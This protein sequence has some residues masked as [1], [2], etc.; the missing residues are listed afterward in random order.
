MQLLTFNTYSYFKNSSDVVKQYPTKNSYVLSNSLY[1]RFMNTGAWTTEYSWLNQDIANPALT[2][3]DYLGEA[4]FSNFA[5][6]YIQRVPGSPS[7]TDYPYHFDK[8]D[9]MSSMIGGY[10]QE[11]SFTDNT[12]N[13]Y[14][15][16][17]SLIN[18]EDL[19]TEHLVY[20]IGMYHYYQNTH[21]QL[22]ATYY[23]MGQTITSEIIIRREIGYKSYGTRVIEIYPE[24]ILKDGA[25]NPKYTDPETPY[26]TVTLRLLVECPYSLEGLLPADSVRLQANSE[27]SI[28]NSGLVAELK[29]VDTENSF[30][31]V[32]DY[33][34]PYAINGTSI[35]EGGTW[36]PYPG[37]DD[38]DGADIPGLPTADACDLG[39]ITMYNPTAAQ[40]KALSQ[41][42]WSNLFDLDSYKKLFSDP[43]ESIIGL[44][45]V[46]VAPSIGGTKTV[47]FGSIDSGISMD[48]LSSQYVQINCG[49]VYINKWVFSFLDSAPYSKIYI[50]LP[51]IGIQELSAD[52]IMDDSINVVYNID[53][54][55]GACGCFIKSGKK[56]VLY[57]FNG[58]CISNIPLT[59]INFSSA[60]Q[61]AVSAVCSGAAIL[62]GMST[63]AA[64]V[65][66]MG[67]MGLLTS[68]ANTAI[69]SKPSVQRSGSLGG[70]SGILS[71]QKP[72][73]IIERPDVSVPLDIQRY[74]GQ[75]CNITENLGNCSG[76]TMIEHIHLHD[77]PATS[78][79]LS[80]IELLLKQ[81]VIL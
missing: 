52:D 17:V 57:S 46:P 74:V 49:E 48:Y 42:M 61:N 63:G 73:V 36:N 70:S 43:M 54:L 75:T 29:N 81:G 60:I 13:N 79:E 76:F 37:I 30:P 18:G 1:E 80:E 65:S 34:N 3:D 9:K 59:S 31:V 72:Y 16:E 35:T 47:R 7:R 11:L 40:M 10:R 2:V 21:D 50:Y 67:A 12:Y 14:A 51:Y 56:G 58:S 62:A 25:I 24:D 55:S 68:A 5:N 19:N 6:E 71:I 64:P 20:Y 45:I 33:E 39:F 26:K 78:E 32:D 8:L 53:C 44:S 66:A 27:R 41:F 15:H 4:C 69:N 38:I 22:Q 23:N 28:L 77:I